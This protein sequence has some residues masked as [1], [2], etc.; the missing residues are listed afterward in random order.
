MSD[1]ARGGP[2]HGEYVRAVEQVFLLVRRQGLML[3]AADWGLAERWAQAGIPLRVVCRA[4]LRAVEGFRAEHGPSRPL[5]A[6]LAYFAPAV[7]DEAALAVRKE[8]AAEEARDDGALD[9]VAR[10]LEDV[11][12]AGRAAADEG[13]RGA[14]RELWREV[15]GLRGRLS[16]GQGASVVAELVGMQER[17]CDRVWAGLPDGERQAIEAEVE[18]LLAPERAALGPHGVQERR[19]ALW[20]RA[21]AAR[22]QLV[23]V[24]EP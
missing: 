18:R 16:R 4:I 21:L 15:A 19:R 1:P 20:E 13:I 14:Y 6:T 10:V 5:P 11:E 22:F 9:V 17:L 7:Q 2:A 8:L 23:R 12:A 24:W 3:S